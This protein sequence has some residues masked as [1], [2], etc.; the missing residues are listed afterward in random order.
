[1]KSETVKVSVLRGAPKVSLVAPKA[2]ALR[3]KLNQDAVRR[4]TY[5]S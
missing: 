4:F 3:L 5:A 1:M 2:P